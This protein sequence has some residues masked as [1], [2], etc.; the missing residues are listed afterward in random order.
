MKMMKAVRIHA[1]GGHD[2]LKYEEAPCPEVGEN[3]ALLR[4]S[5]AGVNPFDWNVRAGYLAGWINYSLPLILGWDVSGV[6][7]AVG[8]GV[9]NLTP[10]QPVFARADYTRDGTYAEFVVVQASLVEPKPTTLDFIHAAAVPHAALAAWQSLFKFA[11]LS[12]GQTVLVHGAAGGVGHFA[13]QFAKLHGAQV[14]GTSSGNNLEFQRQLGV[15][16]AIDYTTTRFEEVVH[17]ADVVLDTI[18]GE[19]QQR[20]W[21]VLKPGGTLVSLVEMPSAETAAAHG[22]RQAL[23]TADADEGVLARIAALI[24]SGQVKP[25]VSTVLPLTEVRQAHAL[26]E[27]RHTRGKIVLQVQD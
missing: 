4:V 21:K 8:T 27:T 9:K 23:A 16:E 1:Y 14:I 24:D 12:K 5:A 22:V 7:E 3:E 26:S 20:S 15:D 11:D 13:V 2:E 10:G 18:G 6:V 25:V 19:V 17:D